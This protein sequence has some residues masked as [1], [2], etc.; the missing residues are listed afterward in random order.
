MGQEVGPAR[1]EPAQLPRQGEARLVMY[2]HRTF[3][4]N[5]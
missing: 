5:R 3:I 4:A 1:G 2:R